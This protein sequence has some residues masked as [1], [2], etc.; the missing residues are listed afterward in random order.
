MSIDTIKATLFT[1][2]HLVRSLRFIFGVFIMA[3]AIT[4]ADVLVGMI[5][6]LFLF[7][8][9][10]NTGCCGMSGCA[11]PNSTTKQATINTSVEYEEIKSGKQD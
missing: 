2:W 4:S 1:N 6:S 3:Q 9:I 5:A 11:I 10:T 8:A 7:Q